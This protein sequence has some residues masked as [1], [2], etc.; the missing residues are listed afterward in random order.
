MLDL[1]FFTANILGSRSWSSTV[2]EH[3]TVLQTLQ[4]VYTDALQ[5]V[6]TDAKDEQRRH[7]R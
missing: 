7:V 6:Y 5:L 3:S 1:P 2:P 4:L